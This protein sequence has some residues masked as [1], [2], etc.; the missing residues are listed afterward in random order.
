MREALPHAALVYD[1]F[2]AVAKFSREVVDRVR[3]DESKQCDEAGRQ[4]SKGSRDLLLKNDDHLVGDQRERL[5]ALLAAN[6]HLNTVYILKDQLKDLWSYR[7][8]GWATRA[9]DAGCA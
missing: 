2:P 6:R 1:R 8:P 4:L 9:L 7:R 3:V 5:D